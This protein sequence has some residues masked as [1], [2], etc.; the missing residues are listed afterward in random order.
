MRESEGE[1]RG[2]NYSRREGKQQ[3]GQV[4]GRWGVVQGNGYWLE[5]PKEE[6]VSEG[7]E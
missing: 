5:G 1:R 2:L 3:E 7:G 6:T 4:E